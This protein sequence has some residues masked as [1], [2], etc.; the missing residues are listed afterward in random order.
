LIERVAGM[1]RDAFAVQFAALKREPEPTHERRVE[2]LAD[3]LG[4]IGAPT[5]VVVGDEDVPEILEAGDAIADGV[6]GARKMVMP[7]AAHAPNLEHPEQFN[8]A[9]LAFLDQVLAE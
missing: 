9:V 6:P 2:R 1:L 7:D 3:H 5:F 8:Q 4:E